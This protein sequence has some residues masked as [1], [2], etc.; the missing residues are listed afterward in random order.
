MFY[1]LR[2]L[3]TQIDSVLLNSK[4]TVHYFDFLKQLMTMYFQT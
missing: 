3:L 2:L 4:E 1:F